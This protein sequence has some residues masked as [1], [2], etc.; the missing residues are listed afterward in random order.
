MAD[1]RKMLDEA[2]QLTGR[3]TSVG[4]LDIRLDIADAT[5]PV[6][7]DSAQIVSAIANI[8]SNAAESYGHQTGPIIITAGTDES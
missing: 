2:V 8:I 6:F 5:G 1:V 3:K 4:D 7:V